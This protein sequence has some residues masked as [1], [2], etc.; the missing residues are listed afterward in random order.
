[1]DTQ[2]N[3]KS[4]RD[5]VKVVELFNPKHP[6]K[7]ELTFSKPKKRKMGKIWSLGGIAAMFAIII[8]VAI[9]LVMPVSAAEVINKALSNLSNAENVKVEFMMRA[10]KTG[11]DGIYRPDLNGNIVNGT[12]FIQKKGDKIFNRIDWDDSERNTIIFD[13]TKYIHLKNGTAVASHPSAFSDELINILNLE[14]Q[15]DNIIKESDISTDGNT[16]TVR[17]SKRNILFTGEFRKDNKQLA[18]ASVVVTGKENAGMVMLETKL[19]D[20]NI[21]IPETMFMD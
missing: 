5:Y 18:K 8:T 17:H 9:K 2:D 3:I 16:I 13:G 11:E 12:L 4:E 21:D 10:V 19:I 6:R 1:M 14:H 20:I 15:P 7:N